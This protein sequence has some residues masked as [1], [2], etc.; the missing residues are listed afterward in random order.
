MKCITEAVPPVTKCTN[1]EPPIRAK[2]TVFDDYC[3]CRLLYSITVSEYC[4]CIISL[5]LRCHAICPNWESN[6]FYYRRNRLWVLEHT[7]GKRIIIDF[8]SRISTLQCGSGR[9]L[10]ANNRYVIT[11][12]RRGGTVDRLFPFRTC[13]ARTTRRTR[14]KCGSEGWVTVVSIDYG[15]LS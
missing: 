13:N 12:G 8:K 11:V 14:N 4:S 9:I 15:R 6:F 5:L 1:C 10:I 3:S 2:S 7:Y